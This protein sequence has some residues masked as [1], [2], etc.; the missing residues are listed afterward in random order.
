MKSMCKWL[1]C[2]IL[3]LVPVFAALGAKFDPWSFRLPMVDYSELIVSGTILGNGYDQTESSYSYLDLSQKL[4]YSQFYQDDNVTLIYS[5][6][7]KYDLVYTSRSI[8]NYTKDETVNKGN[9]YGSI[10]LDRYLSS[11]TD[12]FLGG[13]ASF[14]WSQISK[15]TKE[16][17]GT[18]SVSNIKYD[19]GMRTAQFAFRVGLG[20]IRDVTEYYRIRS[21]AEMLRRRF[22]L[23]ED[24]ITE[25][26]IHRL[27]QLY[28]RQKEYQ[29]KYREPAKKT[30][31]AWIKY[32]NS[33]LQ[34]CLQS[35][36]EIH[37]KIDYYLFGAIAEAR[38]DYFPIKKCGFRVFTEALFQ[39]ER[40]D[41][42]NSIPKLSVNNYSFSITAETEVPMSPV[43]SLGG[44]LRIGHNNDAI[45]EFWSGRL[46]LTAGII[47]GRHSFFDFSAT[48]AFKK[49]DD[50]KYEVELLFSG[51]FT[52]KLSS[53]IFFTLTGSCVINGDLYST[54]FE[55]DKSDW[56]L[57]G[58]IEWRV[59]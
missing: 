4:K 21:I 6:G 25:D 1:Y 3:F 45:G 38:G 14:S 28:F 34:K 26:F 52:V 40:R 32:F 27:A 36:P 55:K 31:Y 44:L 50:D 5:L 13:K 48:T 47:L 29:E 33:D 39:P 7:E 10:E 42:Y 18:T 59:F 16:R 20:K 35:L 23:N 41:G 12:F 53:S 43:F 19:Y 8:T 2:V 49:R 57:S 58:G 22:G 51:D 54:G 30:S 11:K 56:R 15:D 17:F 37:G 46:L 24:D 9:T